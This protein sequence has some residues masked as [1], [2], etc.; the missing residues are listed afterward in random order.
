MFPNGIFELPPLRNF[1]DPEPSDA[2]FRRAQP[3]RGLG[4]ADA[5]AERGGARGRRTPALSCRVSTRRSLTRWRRRISASTRWPIMPNY[6]RMLGEADI[7]FMPLADTAFNR[8]QIRSEIHRGRGRARGRA[9]ERRGV[10][11][12]HPERQD[13]PDLPRRAGIARGLAAAA[14]LSGGHARNRRCGA[15]LCRARA[16]AGLSGRRRGRIGIAACGSAATR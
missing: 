3:R 12:Q 10:W 9:G 8:A 11:R 7:A 2:V 5:R 14:R 15:R 4:A 16:H 1:T 13:R 6:M